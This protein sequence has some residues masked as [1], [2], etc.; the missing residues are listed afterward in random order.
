MKISE[1]NSQVLVA[2]AFAT[3][4]FFS[5]IAIADTA[6]DIAKNSAGIARNKNNLEAVKIE[7]LTMKNRVT[8]VPTEAAAETVFLWLCKDSDYPQWGACDDTYKVEDTGPAGGVVFYTTDGGKHGLEVAL[9]DIK[10][11]SPWGCSGTAITGARGQA[12]GD[13]KANTN[14]ILA[15]DSDCTSVGMKSAAYLAASYSS[16]GI[17]GW[18]LP[19]TGSLKLIYSVIFLNNLAGIEKNS[20]GEDIVYWSST[21]YD[22]N[23]AFAKDFYDSSDPYLLG[24]QIENAARVR[25]VRPF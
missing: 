11:S 19:S 23:S 2:C 21:E 22:S 3:T 17:S 20:S 10:L 16:N 5:H 8:S 9:E 13:G 7:A 18:H 6:G 25:A 12:V 15:T 4:L 24:K 14:A 1:L